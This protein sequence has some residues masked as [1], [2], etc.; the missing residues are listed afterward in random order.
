MEPQNMRGDFVYVRSNGTVFSN[1]PA[2]AAATV[3]EA[4]TANLDRPSGLSTRAALAGNARSLAYPPPVT[5]GTGPYVSEYS[6]QG[7]TAFYGY[8]AVPC[9]DTQFYYNEYG[10]LDVGYLYSGSF[11]IVSQRVVYEPRLGEV[12]CQPVI[13]AESL[14]A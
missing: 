10:Y 12:G 1:R 9:G 3:K 2:L 11:G 7:V 8:V 4:L 5:T 6:G 14:A 13:T